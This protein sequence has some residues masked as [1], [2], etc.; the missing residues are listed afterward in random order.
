MVY[1]IV[2]MSTEVAIVMLAF[3]LVVYLRLVQSRKIAVVAC[4]APRALVAA[5]SLVRLIWL[6]P[7]TPHDKPEYR[8]WL[9]VILSQV[10]V[11]LSI[12]T[13]CIPYMVP[14]SRSRDGSRRCTFQSKSP[15]SQ[16]GERVLHT[17][18]SLWF[19]RQGKSQTVTSWSSTAVASL[20]YERVPQASPHLP[21]HLPTLLPMSPL[22]PPHYNSRPS[23]AKSG[24]STRHGLSINIPERN[25]CLP[26]RPDTTSPQTASS[27]ALSPSCTPLL[28]MYPPGYSLSVPTPPPK[29]YN[30]KPPTASSSHL[31]HS[32]VPVSPVQQ[33]RFTLFPQLVTSEQR[34]SL[35]LQSRC[36][37]VVGSPN[38]PLQSSG[39][40]NI[41]R[42][43]I[44]HSAYGSKERSRS[45]YIMRQTDD[46]APKFST[47]PH[48]NSP[49]DTATSPVS[50]R[51]HFSI[52]ELNSP[53][54]AA[55]NHYFQEAVPGVEPTSPRLIGAPR[56]TLNQRNRQVLSPANTLRTQ[57]ALP[58][59]PFPG[60]SPDLVRNELTLPRDS[61][62]I[63]RSLRSPGLPPVQD[64]RSS[65]RIVVRPL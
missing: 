18:S 60:T 25:M 23:T 63:N 11:C 17:P 44:P 43:P 52:Q 41:S 36:M 24:S 20:Q 45:R 30:P 38:R 26:P 32:P 40:G 12:C 2:D 35:D 49:P 9:P 5:A 16:T 21:T 46:Q 42:Y 62:I 4:F 48:P 58:L 29:A 47:A 39:V 27:S 33:P 10:H 51:R 7:V 57:K 15:N 53:M 50:K 19:R 37:P 22:T 3:N 13:A 14:F 59:S 55:I 61:F 56:S 54:G 28:T 64:A 65:P 6:Y 31:S 8:L 34:H 1:C